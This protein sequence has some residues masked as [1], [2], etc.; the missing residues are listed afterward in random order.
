MTT[1]P[2]ATLKRLFELHEQNK[3]AAADA[4]QKKASEH[5][6]WR[7][8]CAERLQRV[9]AT[10]EQMVV[11]IQSMGHKA[12]ISERIE[13]FLYPSVTFTF[14]VDVARGH[15]VRSSLEFAAT[16]TRTLELRK[17][18]GSARADSNTG[19]PSGRPIPQDI[20]ADF[21]EREV[22]ALVEEALKS[23]ENEG[24]PRSR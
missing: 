16:Q 2:K 4:A 19:V 14:A 13:K 1:D 3:A 15:T 10:L 22:I 6:V 9:K 20:T 11:H 17:T 7:A 24:R 21:V 12:E 18:I 5:D 23:A 8:A